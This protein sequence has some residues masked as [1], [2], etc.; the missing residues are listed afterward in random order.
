MELLPGL[1]QGITRVLISYP[2]D[3]VRTNMQ[4]QK[5]SS[6]SDFFARSQLTLRGAYRGCAVPLVTVPIDRSIQFMIFERLTK[7][8]SVFV[9]SLISSLVSSVYSVPATFL[10]TLMITRSS[11]T[12]QSFFQSRD[13]YRGL[14]PDLAKNYLG[15]V[16]YMSIY[17]SLRK[18]VPQDQH[19]FFVFGIASGIGCWCVIYPLDTVRVMKQTDSRSYREIVR[20]TSLRRY[21]SGFPL[22]VLRSVPSAGFGMVVYEFARKQLDLK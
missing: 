7:G 5:F 22:I 11:Q 10:N 19:N 8:H 6:L 14:A 2:F 9:S 4:T 15:S 18:H 17:G 3:Y 20:A 16:I 12:V 13:F 1:L 21:Y